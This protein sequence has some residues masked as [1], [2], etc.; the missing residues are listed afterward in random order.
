MRRP[1]PYGRQSIDDA[2]IAAVTDALTSD[3]LT[4]GPLVKKFEEEFATYVGAPYAV[5]CA[6]GTAALHLA[7]LALNVSPGQ[8]V[9]T[10][11][12]TFAASSNSILYCAGQIEFVDIDP[13]TF[14]IDIDALERKLSDAP[15]GMYSGIIPVD[16]TGLPVN[17]EKVSALAKEHGLWIIEDACHAPGGF[18]IDS[19]GKEVKCGSGQYSDLICFSFHPVKHITSGEGGMITTADEA[20]YKRLLKLRTHGITRENMPVEKGGWYHEMQVLGYNYRLPDLNCALGIS[21]LKKAEKGLIRRKEIAAKYD[22]AI[23]EI[24]QVT[25]QQQPDGFSNAYHLYVVLV[26]D[27]KG[28]YDFLREKSIFTQVHYIPAHLHPYYQELGWKH[29]DLPKAEAYYDRC[30]SL[31]MYPTLED[32]EQEYVI[33]TIRSFYNQS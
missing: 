23:E 32:E 8:K 28:L 26:E 21:Q 33:E 2:D 3:F 31:P 27:R 22:K 7:A 24:P 13:K 30:L 14:L 4:Q 16:L 18:F 5:C 29:G 10:T 15:K 9:L 25:R 11:P 17:I 20:L 1:I 19:K 6:N 12:I